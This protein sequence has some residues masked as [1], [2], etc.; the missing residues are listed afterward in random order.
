[1]STLGN[2]MKRRKHRQASFNQQSR[3]KLAE[4]WASDCT[5]IQ[6]DHKVYL[7]KFFTSSKEIKY[8][9]Q[10]NPP[11]LFHSKRYLFLE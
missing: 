3:G 9:V 4:V 2:Q 8:L 10:C 7:Y 11:H 5:Q 6:I 1:M